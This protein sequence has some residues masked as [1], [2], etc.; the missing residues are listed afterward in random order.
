ML[1]EAFLTNVSSACARTYISDHTGKDLVVTVQKAM[2]EEH[3]MSY[4]E[5]A[6]GK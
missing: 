3:I 6:A 1:T 2:G 4:K 5:A